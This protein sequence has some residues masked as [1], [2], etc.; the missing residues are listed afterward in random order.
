MSA[1]SKSSDYE[2]VAN[3]QGGAPGATAGRELRPHGRLGTVWA[4]VVCLFR[5]HVPVKRIDGLRFLGMRLMVDGR[6]EVAAEVRQAKRVCLRC[7]RVL[8]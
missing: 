1:G 7:G 4:R 3:G 5:G 6:V 8:K 2:P